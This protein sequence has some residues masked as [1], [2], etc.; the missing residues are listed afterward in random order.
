MNQKWFSILKPGEIQAARFADLPAALEDLGRTLEHDSSRGWRIPGHGGL[1]VWQRDDQS[2]GWTHFSTGKGGDAIGFLTDWADMTFK[3]AVETLLKY[4]RSYSHT[5]RDDDTDFLKGDRSRFQRVMIRKIHPPREIWCDNARE[6]VR[7]AQENLKS[8]RDLEVWHWLH[9]RG[10]DEETVLDAQL[11]WLPR[12][13][14]G[15]RH[16]WGLL[17][18]YNQRGEQKKLWFPKGLLV[19]AFGQ[20][21]DV[22]RIRIRRFSEDPPK[23]YTLPGS[24][25]RPLIIGDIGRPVIVCESDLDALLMNQEAGEIVSLASIGSAGAK[26][27]VLLAAYL[28]VAPKI[29]ISLDAD[30]AGKKASQWW[31]NTFSKANMWPVPWGKDPGDAFGTAPKLV[32]AWIETGLNS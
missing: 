9:K 8:D 24:C 13:Y 4:S 31:L 25:M 14:F 10:S 1:V 18:E 20:S 29:L 23:Y 11:G 3:E 21:G 16:K 30:R 22:E 28:L 27:D 32:K 12:D 26:P 15:R 6:L 2:W 5:E 7:I 19:P 17:E